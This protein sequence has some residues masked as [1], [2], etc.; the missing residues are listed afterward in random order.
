MTHHVVSRARK[1]TGARESSG[2]PPLCLA[3]PNTRMGGIELNG[4]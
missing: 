4:V 2:T 3:P 1:Q